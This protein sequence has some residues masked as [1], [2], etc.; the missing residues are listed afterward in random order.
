MPGFETFLGSGNAN[1]GTKAYITVNSKLKAA[2]LPDKASKIVLYKYMTVEGKTD[3]FPL[4]SVT[5]LTS[6][7]E[8]HTF[9]G[10]DA[11]SYAVRYYYNGTSDWSD[12]T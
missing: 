4:D 2:G 8:S 12:K 10:L 7:I 9:T 1:C 3:Y 11:A 6:I 5:N